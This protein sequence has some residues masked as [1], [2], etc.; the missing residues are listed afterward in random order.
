MRSNSQRSSR[1][2]SSPALSTNYP[3]F[4]PFRVWARR[5][6][7]PWNHSQFH[8]HFLAIHCS[9]AGKEEFD[10]GNCD[11]EERERLLRL[12]EDVMQKVKQLA[13]NDIPGFGGLGGLSRSDATP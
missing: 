6:S 9:L 5:L 11:D 1:I 4:C 12:L 13:E 7:L 8:Y 10:T 2:V 3:L